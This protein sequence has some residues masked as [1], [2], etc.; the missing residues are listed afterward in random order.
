MKGPWCCWKGRLI[1]AP[2]ALSLISVP[3]PGL[4]FAAAC[5][6]RAR[7]TETR[8]VSLRAPPS[9]SS[10]SSSLLAQQLIF[11]FEKGFGHRRAGSKDQEIPSDP[12]G[13]AKAPPPRQRYRAAAEP[14]G[15]CSGVAWRGS[16]P[17][18]L[19]ASLQR[20]RAALSFPSRCC[21]QLSTSLLV[22]ASPVPSHCPPARPG[23]ALSFESGSL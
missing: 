4:G 14:P 23:P 11:P 15:S 5:T 9:F 1:S 17:R 7:P 12:P 3:K 10:A 19:S 2:S 22:L 21:F 18:V 16:S 20:A 8:D 13:R 6:G